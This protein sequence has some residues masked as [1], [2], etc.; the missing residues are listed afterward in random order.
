MFEEI[1]EKIQKLCERRATGKMTEDEE[2]DVRCGGCGQ[3][4]DTY[5][6]GIEQ[7][8]ALMSEEILGLIETEMQP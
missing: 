3:Y 4:D 6:V 5:D 1:V 8:E 7:G 2:F